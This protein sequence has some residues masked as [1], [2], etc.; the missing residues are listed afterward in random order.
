MRFPRVVKVVEGLVKT[1]MP[2]T[3]VKSCS[4]NQTPALRTKVLEEF[5]KEDSDL[6][7]LVVH[8]SVA[9]V[10]INLTAASHLLLYDDFLPHEKTQLKGRLVRMGQKND[11]V[12]VTTLD[13]LRFEK[14]YTQRKATVLYELEAL[15]TIC[16]LSSSG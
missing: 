7:V 16:A 15:G 6:R 10:G 5:S 3:G 13:S 8:Y 9:G 12:S 2:G 1:F 14:S 4:A 11:L